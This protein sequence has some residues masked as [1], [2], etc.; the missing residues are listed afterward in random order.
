MKKVLQGDAAAAIAAATVV[1]AAVDDDGDNNDECS[2]EKIE[3]NLMIM[4]MSIA[5]RKS[6]TRTSL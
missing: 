4:I 5:T 3:N 1:T 2:V 6:R